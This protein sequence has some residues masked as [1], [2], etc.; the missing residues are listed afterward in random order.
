[1]S[2]LFDV[3]NGGTGQTGQTGT[4]CGDP[5]IG[6]R[7]NGERMRTGFNAKVAYGWKDVLLDVL[8]SVCLFAWLVWVFS[9]I[10][11]ADFLK[12]EIFATRSLG[13]HRAPTSS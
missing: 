2:V 10:C 13:A 5:A 4:T 9:L 12:S 11:L 7:G 6:S 1:M 8:T 3:C